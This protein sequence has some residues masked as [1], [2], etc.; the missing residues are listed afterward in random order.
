MKFTFYGHSC[1]AIE[2]NGKKL[3]FDPFISGN[4]LASHI[5]ITSLSADYIF[6]SHGHAD[7]TADLVNIALNTGAMV[8]SNFEIITWAQGK[9]VTNVHPMNFGTKTF[10][11]GTVTFFHAQHS[12]SFEDGSYA[13]NPGG[14]I[15][16]TEKG[17][18]YYSGDTGLM[19]DMQLVPHFA[20]PDW[21][22]LP[23]GGNF[24]MDI[25]DAIK[26]SDFITCNNIIGVH[27]D[28]FGYIKIDK[29]AALEMFEKAGKKLLLPKIGVAY[30]L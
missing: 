2:I 6:V 8:V 14:F 13:G 1:F 24:T 16:A 23:V 12:S 5:D 4:E 28:T 30:E 9:G 26:A 3:L 20:K 18:F 25:N 21:A 19:L 29:T 10:D 22:V 27:F 17:N 15:I 7:H 11:F